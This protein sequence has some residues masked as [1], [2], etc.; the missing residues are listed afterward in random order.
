MKLTIYPKNKNKVHQLIK[1]LSEILNI[2]KSV[3]VAPILDSSLAVFLYT[4]DRTIKVNDIDL[5]CPGRYFPKILKALRKSGIKSKIKNH[6]IRC[7]KGNLKIEFGDP[8]YWYPEVPIESDEI[9]EIDNH[10]IRVLK[11]DSL[12]LFYRIG[13]LDLKK[14][15]PEKQRKYEDVLHK[16]NILKSYEQKALNAK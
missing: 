11:L 7:T 12:I 10:K 1:F 15:L 4:K 6:T 14:Q 9:L 2:C 13:A 5:N 16:I 3:N 8:D